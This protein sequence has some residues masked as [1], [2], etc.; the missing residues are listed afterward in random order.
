MGADGDHGKFGAARDLN[1]VEVAITVAGV[2]RLD[3]NGD[4]EIALSGMTSSL[5]AGGVADAIGLMKRVRDV[6]CEGTLPP[7]AL[8]TVPLIPAFVGCAVAFAADRSS[9]IA[10]SHAGL[11]TL[12]GIEPSPYAI[13]TSATPRLLRLR[14]PQSHAK[15]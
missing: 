3:G 11:A 6:V 9:R 14:M 4:E 15:M 10:T 7:E 13:H 5:P 8:V 1:H 2:E 12:Q